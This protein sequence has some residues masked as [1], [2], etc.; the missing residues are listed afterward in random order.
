MLEHNWILL[1]VFSLKKSKPEA[2][3]NP[4]ELW[5]DEAT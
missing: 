2:E 4:K 1:G 5:Q 3:Q